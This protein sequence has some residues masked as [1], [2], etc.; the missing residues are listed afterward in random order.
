[1]IGDTFHS[2]IFKQDII[3]PHKRSEFIKLSIALISVSISNYLSNAFHTY[4]VQ[5]TPSI[6]CAANTE[7]RVVLP[8]PDDPIMAS[9]IPA[10]Q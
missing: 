2:Q 4:P 5:A 8:E 9:I 1:M 7:R 6:L 10:R 3:L